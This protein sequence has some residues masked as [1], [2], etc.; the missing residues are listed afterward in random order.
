[1]FTMHTEN[2]A[3]AASAKVLANVKARYGFVPNLAGYLAESPLALDMLMKLMAAYD[4]A[5]LLPQE[6]QVVLLTASVV[7]DCS[8]CRT[9]HSALARKAGV[10]RS[11]LEA[12]TSMQSSSDARL[13][14]VRD[15]T[16]AM[17]EQR[18]FVGDEAIQT[19]LAAGFTQEQVLEVVLGVA[20]KTLTNY[21]N[22]IV[23]TEP[24]QEFVQ[25]ASM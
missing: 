10:S 18:G 7:N 12:L 5:T 14:A 8:Y 17:V 4:G 21:S 16:R 24:N 20:I 3:P 9:A 23:G 13:N 19:F 22:H 25:M 15:F 11:D 2:T 1:M 6:Q